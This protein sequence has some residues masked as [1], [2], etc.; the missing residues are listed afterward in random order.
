MR[1]FI[2]GYAII[3]LPEFL[4]SLYNSLFRKK[5]KAKEKINVVETWNEK[6]LKERI[7]RLESI[8]REQGMIL[9]S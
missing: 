1:S 5:S 9:K 8:I 4:L 2:S 3:Q 6:S 7:E